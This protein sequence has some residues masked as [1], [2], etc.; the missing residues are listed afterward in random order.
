MPRPFGPPSSRY[1]SPD[2]S[3]I[4]GAILTDAKI[5]KYIRLGFYGADA[6][7]R[8]AEKPKKPQRLTTSVQSILAKLS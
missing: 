2:F 7:A 5:A 1:R 8:L 6:Q 3:T 4:R